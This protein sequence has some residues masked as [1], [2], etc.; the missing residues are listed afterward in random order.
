ML[1]KAS[2]RYCN[3]PGCKELA[4]FLPLVLVPKAGQP[5]LPEH[6]MEACLDIPLCGKH[7][8]EFPMN[9]IMA[10]SLKNMFRQQARV[11]LCIPDFNRAFKGATRM[12]G[13]KHK[14]LL[15]QKAARQR[16]Q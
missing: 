6:S 9:E 12:G 10:E 1:I 13:P 14:K 4:G 7:K 11:T 3:Y 8:M 16:P 5:K 15:A 2:E